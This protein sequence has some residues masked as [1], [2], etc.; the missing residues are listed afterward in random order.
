MN[1]TDVT[2]DV[3][4]LCLTVCV[5]ADRKTK[6]QIQSLSYVGQ[7]SSCSTKTRKTTRDRYSFKRRDRRDWILKTKGGLK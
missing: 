1:T 4:F 2:Y 3:L 6:K 5:F 7:R